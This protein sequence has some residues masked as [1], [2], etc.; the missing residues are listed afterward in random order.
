MQICTYICTKVNRGYYLKFCRTME[1]MA[2]EEFSDSEK[3]IINNISAVT[4]FNILVKQ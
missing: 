2:E 4:D 3:I 1:N